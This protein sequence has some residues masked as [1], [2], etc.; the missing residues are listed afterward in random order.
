M[1]KVKKQESDK[2]NGEWERGRRRH[3]KRTG[4][5]ECEGKKTKDWG[6]GVWENKHKFILGH[7]HG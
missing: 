3:E 4:F 7:Y 6:E 1:E 2:E 5:R